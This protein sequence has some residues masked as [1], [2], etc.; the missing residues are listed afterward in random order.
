MSSSFSLYIHIPWCWSKCPYCDFNAYA[1]S[2]HQPDFEH[3]TL[4]LIADLKRSQRHAPFLTE[5]TSIYLGG[6]TPSLMPPYLLEK[7]LN[8]IRELYY[9]HTQLEV[10][11]EIS[12]KTQASY[13]SDVMRLGVNRFSVGLQSFHPDVLKILGREHHAGESHA[14]IDSLIQVGS[15]NFNIDLIYGLAAQSP[16]MVV[17]DLR[18]GLSAPIEHLSWY[19]LM[20]EPNTQFA[21]KPELK[22]DQDTLEQME[23]E[24]MILI[25]ESGFKHYE[26]SAYYKNRPSQHNSHYWKYGDYIGIGAGAHSKITLKPKQTLRLYKTRYPKDYLKSPKVLVDSI[27]D[28]AI[29][30][31]INRLR[32][33]TP[34]TFHEIESCLPN[35]AADHII[36]WVNQLESDQLLIVNKESFLLTKRGQLLINDLLYQFQQWRQRIIKQV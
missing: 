29:D 32:L 7:L 9:W 21:K 25:E 5:L 35:Q 12:P 11:M 16:E 2:T 4:Q 30:Y 13:L 10:T 8:T 15:D 14:I 20:L 6:G 23:E 19:E 33:F 27:A 18:L 34:I 17:E 31:L 26:V 3:Y 1:I 28:E 22:T 24:G 36:K